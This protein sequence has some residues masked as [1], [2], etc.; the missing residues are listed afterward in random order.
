MT[1]Q[2]VGMDFF[3]GTVQCKL[4]FTSKRTLFTWVR[5]VDMPKTE[6]QVCDKTKQYTE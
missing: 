4:R 3:Y 6:S 2:G 5:L 1:L